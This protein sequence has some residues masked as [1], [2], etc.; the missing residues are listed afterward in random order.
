[1]GVRFAP[2]VFGSLDIS[3]VHLNFG[4]DVC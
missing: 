1:V 4:G 3:F 2:N